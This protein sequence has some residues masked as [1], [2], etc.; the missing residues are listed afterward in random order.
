MMGEPRVQ[1]CDLEP[2]DGIFSVGIIGL[3]TVSDD[4]LAHDDSSRALANASC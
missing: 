3:A 4:Q 2:N 1:G